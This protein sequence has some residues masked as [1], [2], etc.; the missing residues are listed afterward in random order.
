MFGRIGGR[1]DV[2][3]RRSQTVPVGDL[4]VHHAIAGER[5]L[6]GDGRV[7][8]CLSELQSVR[9]ICHRQNRAKIIQRSTNFDLRRRKG[10]QVRERIACEIR[11]GDREVTGGVINAGLEI[12]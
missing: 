4:V 1:G 6:R 2:G 3:L 12:S 11:F 8:E 7:G 10:N 5:E 9:D